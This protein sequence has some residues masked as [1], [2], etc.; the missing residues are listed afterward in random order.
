MK[1]EW[2]ILRWTQLR[3][4]AP[5]S[6]RTSAPQL[7]QNACHPLQ[8][9][10]KSYW[11][12]ARLPQD[13]WE[14]QTKTTQYRPVPWMERLRKSSQLECEVPQLAPRWPIGS[15][16]S[17]GVQ[18]LHSGWDVSRC[19]A[20]FSGY[21]APIRNSFAERLTATCRVQNLMALSK[22]GIAWY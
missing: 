18:W 13:H 3:R 20:V 10:G 16:C 2:T 12:S 9:P 5:S 7:L 21:L 1:P 14:C 4:T 8:I 11:R 17:T 15:L 19:A 22:W 6:Q